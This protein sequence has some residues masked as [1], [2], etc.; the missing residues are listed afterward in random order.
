MKRLGSSYFWCRISR[1]YCYDLEDNVPTSF[2]LMCWFRYMDRQLNSRTIQN[3][4]PRERYSIF[5]PEG[6]ILP[7]WS[8]NWK[9]IP[10]SGQPWVVAS[11]Y[12]FCSLYQS[13]Y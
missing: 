7:S 3:E 10:T 8:T 11:S 13:S 1:L 2:L 4:L 12:P 9:S 6:I 5:T